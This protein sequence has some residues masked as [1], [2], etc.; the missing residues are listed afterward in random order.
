M[1]DDNFLN[2]KDGISIEEQKEILA[3]I[4][5]IA[6]K[7]RR[8]L[9][10]GTT[11]EK[12]PLLTKKKGAV[13]P[14]IVNIGAC[15]IL[16]AGAFLLFFFNSKI[17]TQVRTGNTVY[18]GTERAIID[19]LRRDSEFSSA[20]KELERLTTERER[21]LAMESLFSNLNINA[22][23]GS[24]ELQSQNTQLQE[25][26]TEMQ[27]TIDVL[28]SGGT[29]LTVRINQLE[30]TITTLRSTNNSLEQNVSE[31]DSRISSLETENTN[32]SS[33]ITRLRNANAIQEQEIARLRNRIENILQAAQ[34]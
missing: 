11:E 33:E 19:E 5:G 17:D 16:T 6:E 20:I 9:S 34:E 27:K 1:N 32:F 24:N 15:I 28:S 4:N 3:Q 26:I 10:G 30:E 14:L 13:F 8:S 7:N 29:G 22:G 21:F 31:K 12:L 2:E 25:T 18:D 23:S